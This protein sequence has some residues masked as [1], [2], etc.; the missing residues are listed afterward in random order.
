MPFLSCRDFSRREAEAVAAAWENAFIEDDQKTH[1][2]VAVRYSDG[3][4]MDRAWNFE[5]GG[6]EKINR[7]LEQKGIPA[8]QEADEAEHK[9]Q[10]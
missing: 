9:P 5:T 7:Y 10:K 2:R 1:F 4:L 3:M 8:K 6:G